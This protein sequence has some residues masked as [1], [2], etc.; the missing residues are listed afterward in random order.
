MSRTRQCERQPLG[1]P[2]SLVWVTG[3]KTHGEYMVSEL[4]QIPDIESAPN[5]PEIIEGVCGTWPQLLRG[6]AIQQVARVF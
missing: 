4:S 5:Q 6:A 2:K 1:G 3:G